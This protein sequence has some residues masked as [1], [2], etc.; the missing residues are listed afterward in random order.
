MPVVMP[1]AVA[2]AAPYGV[3]G[4][5]A[6]HGIDAMGWGNGPA[7]LSAARHPSLMPIGQ[8]IWRCCFADS[9]MT[10]EAKR[11]LPAH[12]VIRGGVPS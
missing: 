6:L 12:G 3:F 2:V 11:V 1:V 5:G 4:R 8:G 10:S 9:S 7:G